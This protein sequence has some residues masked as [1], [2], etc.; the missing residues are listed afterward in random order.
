MIVRDVVRRAVHDRGDEARFEQLVNIHYADGV[1][2]QT[3]GGIVVTP[4]LN[5]AFDACHFAE[6][7]FARTGEE[8]LLVQA[9]LVT[10]REALELNP[11]IP[12]RRR[13]TVRSVLTKSE[14]AEYRLYHRWYPVSD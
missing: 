7:E 5:H 14:I 13:A 11:Q 2:M 6:L 4:A 10:M 9:P 3:F 8:A 12:P 1:H